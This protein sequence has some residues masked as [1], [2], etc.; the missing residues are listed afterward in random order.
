MVR[1]MRQR[2]FLIQ[3][4]F[5]LAAVICLPGCQAERPD[6]V[7]SPD[8][9]EDVLY[10]YHVAQ[11]LGRSHRDS[12][13]YYTAVYEGAVLKKYG[14]SAAQFDETLAWYSRHAEDLYE[15]YKK[16]NE[17]LAVAT[18][19]STAT[20]PYA[21]M[22]EGGDTANVWQGAPFYILTNHGKNYL[23]FQ[24]EADTAYHPH[25]RLILHFNAQWVYREGAREAVATLAVRYANDSLATVTQYLSSHNPQEITLQT[26]SL[27]VKA[28]TGFVYQ[29][30]PWAERPKLLLLTDFVLIRIHT[31]LA[32]TLSASR[33]RLDPPAQPAGVPRTAQQRL[34][35]SLLREDSVAR[36]R[37]LAKPAS[38]TT[39]SLRR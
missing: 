15:T 10:D 14:I 32:D 2:Q 31:A 39:R 3:F 6:G 9:L 12:A 19:T 23:T 33:L 27:P 35:D 18:A 7:L 16:V 21:A 17:R 5:F 28:V 1:K 30:A 38:L 11:S 24:Q 13:Q 34:R 8:E 36:V 20:N 25:D 22:R 37:P 26:D 29:D 4:F